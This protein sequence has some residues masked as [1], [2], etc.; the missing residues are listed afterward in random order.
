LEEQ[1]AD[2]SSYFN[3]LREDFETIERPRNNVSHEALMPASASEAERNLFL[4]D[5]EI[6]LELVQRYELTL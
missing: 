3:Y 2:L 1:C 4:S 5:L 6:V